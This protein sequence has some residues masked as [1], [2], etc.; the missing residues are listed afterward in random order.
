M[1]ADIQW[2]LQGEPFLTGSGRLIEVVSDAVETVTGTRPQQSTGGGTSDGRFIAPYGVEV[3][4]LG[5]ANDTIHQ[6]N[7]FV[8]LDDVDALVRMYRGIME[9][10]LAGVQT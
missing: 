3:V 9:R 7:E 5:P 8:R 4:E 1:A 6:V 10:L 2:Q